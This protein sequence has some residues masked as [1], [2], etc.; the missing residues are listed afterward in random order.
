MF[1]G[2]TKFF[3]EWPSKWL[4]AVRIIARAYNWPPTELDKL[5][6]RYLLFWHKAAINVLTGKGY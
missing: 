2:G 6:L 1:G 3:I 4:E 5:N